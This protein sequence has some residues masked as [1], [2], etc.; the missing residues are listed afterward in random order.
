MRWK[1]FRVR[2]TLWNMGVLALVLGAFGLTLFLTTRQRAASAIDQ[3]LIE[4]GLRFGDRPFHRPFGSRRG[5]R[6]FRRDNTLG[7]PPPPDG[8]KPGPP[9]GS[10]FDSRAWPVDQDTRRLA[11]IRRP[12]L[13]GLDGR[14]LGP[15]GM[16]EPW[17]ADSFRR[18][19]EGKGILSTV[20]NGGDRVRVFSMPWLFDRRPVAVIQ[21]AE[22]LSEYDRQGSRQIKTLLTLLPAALLIAGLGGMFLTD[23]ALRPVRDVTFA[24]SRI[25]EEDLSRRLEVAGEDELA[26]LAHTFNGMIARLEAAFRSREEAYARLEAAFEQQ[27]RFTAD[28]SHELRTPLARIK[29]STSMALAGEESL[30]EYRTAL[31]TADRAADVMERLISQLLTLAR[32]DAGQL[33]LKKEKF[34]LSDLLR[35]AVSAFPDTAGREVSLDLP[36]DPQE[37]EADP[38][39][40]IRVFLNLLEN[41]L[42]HTPAGGRIAV[43]ARS[44]GG[45]IVVVVADDG[46]G[47]PPEHLPY[48]TERFYRVGTARSRQAG[49]TGLGLAICQSILHAHGGTLSLESQAGKGTTATVR[50]P[51]S[52]RS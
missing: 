5:G 12:R 40:L 4:R 36:S 10:F 7:P 41:A 45:G 37:I 13:I 29:V 19:L 28:A 43:S 8:P 21:I 27:R 11:A 51:R 52:L 33:G 31:E 6:P 26:R 17:D 49:G 48:I 44:E 46:E 47:I 50:L 25:G 3:A 2:L 18:S 9:E 30:E 34:D 38:G 14:V 42:R 1:S 22:D 35:E 15:P 16:A 32:A 20:R 24:A 23:R 39:H